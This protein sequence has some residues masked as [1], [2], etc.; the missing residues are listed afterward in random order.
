MPLGDTA[1]QGICGSLGSPEPQWHGE[2]RTPS[3]LQT[4]SPPSPSPP[5]QGHVSAPVPLGGSWPAALPSPADLAPAFSALPAQ[6]TRVHTCLPPAQAEV[7]LEPQTSLQVQLTATD[8][9]SE[10][11][12]EYLEALENP[13]EFT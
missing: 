3:L 5:P 7:S 13:E 1:S 6:R 11:G 9:L 2:P 4:L 8:T 10:S 12:S